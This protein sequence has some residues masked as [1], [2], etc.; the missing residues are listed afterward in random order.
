MPLLWTTK[1]LRDACMDLPDAVSTTA[2]SVVVRWPKQTALEAAVAAHGLQLAG[3]AEEFNNPLQNRV[4]GVTQAEVEL[5]ADLAGLGDWLAKT[6]LVEAL[7]ALSSRYADASDADTGRVENDARAAQLPAR[8][9]T[10]ELLIQQDSSE[11]NGLPYGT[12]LWEQGHE[13]EARRVWKS[14]GCLAV[15]ARMEQE[16]TPLPADIK[17]LPLSEQLDWLVAAQDA[18]ALARLGEQRRQQHPTLAAA[19]FYEASQLHVEAREAEA[20]QDLLVRAAQL[21]HEGACDTLLQWRPSLADNQQLLETL[22]NEA[23]TPTQRARLALARWAHRQGNMD[24]VRQQ[25]LPDGQPR[26]L[27]QHGHALVDL[28][29]WNDDQLDTAWSEWLDELQ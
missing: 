15:L 21:G 6:R 17:S 11:A 16:R 14:H 4:R 26:D 20:A 27:V 29:L 18:S 12:W 5:L 3:L 1:D 19:M 22:V 24:V 8:I 7:P 2:A 13:D 10:S 28:G 23:P 25:L 9:T